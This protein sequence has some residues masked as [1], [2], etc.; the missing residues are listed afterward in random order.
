MDEELKNIL[1]EGETPPLEEKKEPVKEPE[2]SPEDAE[3]KKKEEIKANLDKAIEES[4][5]ILRKNREAIKDGKKPEEEKLPE[6]NRE[7]P[8]TKVW[9]KEIDSKT[10]PAATQLEKTQQEIFTFTLREFL[11]SHP[12]LATNAEKRKEFVEAYERNKKSS[13]LTREGVTMDLETAYGATFHQELI[14]AARGQRFQRMETDAA[15][16]DPAVSRGSTTYS[17]GKESNDI[18]L[19]EDDKKEILKMGYTSVSEWIADKKKFG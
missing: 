10:A 1:G 9:L 4:N 11:Q 18:T 8:E 12:F 2:L 15:F 17:V 14:S 6:L 5:E 19:T 16:S 13:G 7:A 3:I